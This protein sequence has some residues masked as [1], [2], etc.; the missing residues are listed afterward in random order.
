MK[1]MIPTPLADLKERAKIYATAAALPKELQGKPHEILV[2]LDLAEQIGESYWSVLQGV[3]VIHGRPMFGAEFQIGRLMRSG[4]IAGPLEYQVK[5]DPQNPAVRC[6]AKD[7]RTGQDV[8]G[9]VVDLAM[10]KGDGWTRNAK[11]KDPKMA[12]HMLRLRA[13]TF[14][15]RLNYPHA[16]A[17]GLTAEEAEDIA[18]MAATPATTKNEPETPTTKEEAFN[19]IQTQADAWSQSM[20]PP[21][22]HP[23]GVS[24]SS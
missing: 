22:N 23:K 4:A 15:I 17:Q 11:Y 3:K 8:L 19:A 9:P 13:A 5:E 24:C 2:L 1:V 10:A 7:A 20:A 6:K 14:F 12:V 21:M 18:P 16:V